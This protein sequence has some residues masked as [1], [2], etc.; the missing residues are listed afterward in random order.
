RS[1][2][3]KGRWRWLAY[4]V[5][6]FSLIS[7]LLTVLPRTLLPPVE[8]WFNTISILGAYMIWGPVSVVLAARLITA[9][10]WSSKPLTWSRWV[11]QALAVIFL[12]LSLYADI[13]VLRIRDSV[14]EDQIAAAFFLILACI[15]G[16]MAGVA[17][18]WK[19]TGPKLWVSLALI[20]VLC[21]VQFPA[22]S[23]P[24][25]FSERV[26]LER[27]AQVDAAIQRYHAQNGRYPASLIQLMPRYLLWVPEPVTYYK[28]VWCYD[29]NQQ[30]YRL[31]YYEA[32]YY[33]YSL[34]GISV[35][36]YGSAGELP[37]QPTPC[38]LDLQAAINKEQSR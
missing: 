31:G 12:A 33:R 30:Y 28:S 22:L 11:P 23:L 27:A 21:A 20:L 24:Q 8:S 36:L 29:G 32:G 5:F 37:Q 16:I 14:T 35:K 34:R 13:R 25:N 15:A 6:G 18:A 9:L 3:W 17:S 4:S 2:E 38:D 26:T 1:W 19:R 7:L 10:S